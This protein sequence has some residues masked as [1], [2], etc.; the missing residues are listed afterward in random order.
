MLRSCAWCGQFMG[1]KPPYL[2]LRTTHGIC[3]W[4]QGVF[5]KQITH[6]ELTRDQERSQPQWTR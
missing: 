1:L 3:E 5:T 4:C 6:S 2:D